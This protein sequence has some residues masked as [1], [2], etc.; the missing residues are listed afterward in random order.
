MKINFGIHRGK[1]ISSLSREELSRT[2]DWIARGLAENDWPSMKQ[3]EMK[4]WQIAFDVALAD[5]DTTEEELDALTGPRPRLADLSGS[6]RKLLDAFIHI[7][8][9][10]G[11]DPFP[12]LRTELIYLSGITSKTFTKAKD[13]LKDSGILTESTRADYRLNLESVE[14]AL[15]PPL[16]LFLFSVVEA[17]EQESKSG[18]I[19]PSRDITDAAQTGWRILNPGTE[20]SDDNVRYARSQLSRILRG[21]G[22]LEE[23]M[24]V[25][26]WAR[27][28]YSSGEDRFPPLLDLVYIWTQP[29]F[30]SYLAAAKTPAPTLKIGGIPDVDKAEK[31]NEELMERM[32]KRGL[33]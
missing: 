9:R 4:R 24:L 30:A 25:A 15:S 20:P 11:A 33:A 17:V 29:R 6:A 5:D 14:N 31:F 19:P 32:K 23:A 16:S 22:T 10:E 2:R 8:Q 1:Q 26:R 18:E 3:R 13:Q 21:G 27:R 12:A 7:R 28:V